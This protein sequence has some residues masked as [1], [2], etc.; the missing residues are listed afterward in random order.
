MFVGA[1]DFCA[2]GSASTD[3]PFALSTLGETSALAFSV[4][5]SDITDAR[6]T[7]TEIDSAR[8]SLSIRASIPDSDVSPTGSNIRAQ[9]NS[10]IKRGAVAPRI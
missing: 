4:F 7:G 8:S 9:I 5:G 1:L 3:L 6:L 2:E 10:S